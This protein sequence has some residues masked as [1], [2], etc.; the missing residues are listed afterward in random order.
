VLERVLGGPLPGIHVVFKQHPGELDIGPYAGLLEGLAK[1]GG[2]SAPNMTV[3]REIDL[4]RLLRVADAHL[5]YQSTVLTDAV[6]AGTHNLIAVGEPGSD[7]LGYAAAG[8]AHPVRSVADVRGELDRPTVTD[9]VAR[10]RFIADHFRPGDASSRI[11]RAIEGHLGSP[12]EPQP[13]E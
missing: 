8:V 12:V 7:V 13:I 1:A 9:P 11:V 5:G 6:V 4:L 2:Y 3:V 10:D